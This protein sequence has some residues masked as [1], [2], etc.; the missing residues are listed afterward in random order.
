MTVQGSE[1]E[2]LRMPVASMTKKLPEEGRGMKKSNHQPGH[3]R[4]VLKSGAEC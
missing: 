2:G 1:E 3:R 4:V